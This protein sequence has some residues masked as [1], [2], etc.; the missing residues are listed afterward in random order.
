MPVSI[1]QTQSPQASVDNKKQKIIRY[2]LISLA[3][4]L[5]VGLLGFGV[6]YYVRVYRNRETFPQVTNSV[7]EQSLI[8]SGF[9][10]IESTDKKGSLFVPTY[11]S[12][13]DSSL[14]VYG[15]VLNGSNAYIYSYPNSVGQIDSTTCK[16]FAEKSFSE[17]KNVSTFVNASLGESGLKKI[18]NIEGCHLK[19]SAVVGQK[20]YEIQNFYVFTKNRIYQ[21]Y[22]Q[23]PEE[24]QSEKDSAEITLGS[25]QVEN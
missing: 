19:A 1:T 20:T 13:I 23:Y 11:W 21:T 4:I 6:Y 15:D 3:L 17:L 2:S 25:I 7:N 22:I 24:L 10:K 5:V 18:K 14:N 9:K 16:A 8:D 12:S